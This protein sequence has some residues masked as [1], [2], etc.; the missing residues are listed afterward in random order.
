MAASALRDK[1]GQ[2]EFGLMLLIGTI[3]YLGGFLGLRFEIEQDYARRRVAAFRSDPSFRELRRVAMVDAG[4]K[5]AS[6]SFT[7]HYSY[8]CFTDVELTHDFI[9]AWA[10]SASAVLVPIRC[11]ASRTEAETFANDLRCRI[12]AARATRANNTNPDQ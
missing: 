3:G 10:S 8:R 1:A 11:F 4:L 7:A 6:A 2:A 5:Y 12:G 9:L